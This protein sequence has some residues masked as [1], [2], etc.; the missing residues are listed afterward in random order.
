MRST[1]HCLSWPHYPSLS[2]QHDSQSAAIRFSVMGK[3]PAIDLAP[4]VFKPPFS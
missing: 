4:M 2:C 1:Y 3:G